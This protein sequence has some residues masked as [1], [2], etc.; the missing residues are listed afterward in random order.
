MCIRDRGKKQ[1][2]LSWTADSKFTELYINGAYIGSYQLTQSIKIDAKRMSLNKAFGQIVENDPHYASDGV[3][4]FKGLSGMPFSFK[5]PD[6]WKT[7]TDG[8]VDPE[9]LTTEKVTAE[10]CIRDS[11]TRVRRRRPT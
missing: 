10:M 11:S 9:G 3:P 5:D 6:E 2:G 4:G 7:K 1:N 8:S